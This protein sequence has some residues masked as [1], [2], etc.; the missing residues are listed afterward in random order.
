MGGGSGWS[1][2]EAAGLPLIC[3]IVS[4]EL[5]CADK[6]P[7]GLAER[8]VHLLVLPSGRCSDWLLCPM[9][10]GGPTLRFFL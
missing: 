4:P 8:K 7:R 2:E 6:H 1:T 5:L 10:S 3:M 9:L